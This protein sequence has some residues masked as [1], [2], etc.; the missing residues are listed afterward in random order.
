MIR[1]TIISI[2]VYFESMCAKLVGIGIAK[3]QRKMIENDKVK[4][5]WE[6]N[7]QIGRIYVFTQPNVVIDEERKKKNSKYFLIVV[8]ILSNN[9]TKFKEYTDIHIEIARMQEA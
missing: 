7:I 1:W 8:D 2:S 6:I 5:L 9:N 3:N 4:N